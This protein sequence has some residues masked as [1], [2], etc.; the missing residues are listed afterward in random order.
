MTEESSSDTENTGENKIDIRRG[1]VDSLSIYE[2]KDQEL[3]ILQQGSL[4]S[5]FLNLAIFLLSVGASFLAT[6]L[7]ST[8]QSDRKFYFFAIVVVV[9]TIVGGV[10][11]ILWFQRKDSVSSIV[12]EIKSRIPSE[13]I[14]TPDSS[15]SDDDA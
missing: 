3:T 11:L 2:V 1:R 15:A 9:A 6:L 14:E 13:K 10:L 5:T 4:G 8:I 12:N 7:T